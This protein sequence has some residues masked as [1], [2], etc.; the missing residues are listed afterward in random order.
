MKQFLVENGRKD[1]ITLLDSRL[2]E[3]VIHTKENLLKPLIQQD[4]ISFGNPA[5]SFANP[6]QSTTPSISPSSSAKSLRA[7]E[8]DEGSLASKMWLTPS[9]LRSNPI[10]FI[11]LGSLSNG[12]SIKETEN[13][14]II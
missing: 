1:D 10:N 7:A 4:R 9:I 2:P 3:P 14:V 13:P 6:H 5:Q 8:E 12:L 11:R